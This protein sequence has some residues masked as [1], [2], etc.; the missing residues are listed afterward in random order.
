MVYD[1]ALN[2]GNFDEEISEVL[3]YQGEENPYS[4]PGPQPYGALKI[5][6]EREAEV[7]FPGRALLLRLG[8]LVGPGDWE[9][10]F[11]Y[12]P[13]R[14]ARGGEV[15]VAGNPSIPV[16]IIDVRDVAEWSI[17]MVERQVTGVFNVTGPTG[18]PL[19]LAGVLE[20]AR[21]DRSGAPSVTWVPPPFL[22]GGDDRKRW[23]RLLFW[24]HEVEGSAPFFRMSIERARAEG[25]NTRPLAETA[26]DT[27]AW[28]RTLSVDRQVELLLPR[29]LGYEDN[30]PTPQSLTAIWDD[31]IR[32]EAEEV[33]RWLEASGKTSD[34]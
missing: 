29:F 33:A 24:T 21:S 11:T 31:Y 17:R 3:E 26:A 20:D 23:Y 4:L 34:T 27:L 13:E 16:Q 30:E 9:G 7:Q 15:L 14:I 2:S 28:H 25:L 12:W 10:S 5:L 32:R 1:A 22:T 19:T 18:E 6:C 8:H